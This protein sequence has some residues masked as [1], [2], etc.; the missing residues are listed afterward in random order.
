MGDPIEAARADEER[1]ARL[2]DTWLLERRFGKAPS[3]RP[4]TTRVPT[5]FER[6]RAESRCGSFAEWPKTQGL[7]CS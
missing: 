1:V 7:P 4:N 3:Q 5:L 2:T 6:Y